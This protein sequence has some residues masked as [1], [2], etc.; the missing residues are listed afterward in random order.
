VERMLKHNK[1]FVELISWSLSWKREDYFSYSWKENYECTIET[2]I[3]F[4]W[5]YSYSWARS[6]KCFEDWK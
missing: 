4:M 2:N 6:K 5:K 1:V 3:Y